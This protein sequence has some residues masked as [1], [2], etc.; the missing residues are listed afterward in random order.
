MKV[1]IN[2][3]LHD[4]GAHLMIKTCKIRQNRPRNWYVVQWIIIFVK[5]MILAHIIKSLLSW[6]K[7]FNFR[8]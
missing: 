6:K 8:E 5:K 7:I 4:P 1:E 2:S 3:I